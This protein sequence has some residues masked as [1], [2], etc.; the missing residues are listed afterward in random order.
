MKSGMSAAVK[1]L[2]VTV[3]V[4]AGAWSLSSV[5]Y[6]GLQPVLLAEIGYNDAPITYSVYYSAWAAAVFMVFRRTFMQAADLSLEPERVAILAAMALVFAGFALFVLP[7]LPATTWTRDNSPVEFFWA[8]SWYF[9]P[10]SLEI[11]F[12]QLLIAA[13]VLALN[14]LRLSIARVALLTA[15]LFGTFHLTLAL[16]YPNPFYVMR[17]SVAAT[18]FGALVPWLILRLRHGFLI[19]YAIHWG[20][21]A[22]DAMLIHVAFAA[23]AGAAD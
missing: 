3:L 22:L 5:G 13:L 9:L 4:V 23:G 20:Y 1:N 10:K 15:A 12:Q 14:D 8:N 17:Y 19:S 16:S 18:A 6:F 2:L 11:L 21:Y 7:R